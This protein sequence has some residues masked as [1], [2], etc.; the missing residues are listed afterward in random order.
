MGRITAIKDGVMYSFPICPAPVAARQSARDH[1]RLAQG[2]KP[3]RRPERNRNRPPAATT[4]GYRWRK[5]Q[6]EERN[7]LTQ[8]PPAPSIS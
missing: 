5:T 4:G 2:R 6:G 1:R 3:A 8:Y 7:E